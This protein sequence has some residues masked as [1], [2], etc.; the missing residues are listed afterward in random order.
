VLVAI[1]AER[2]RDSTAR[3][4]RD[5]VPALTL[6][7]DRGS[8]HSGDDA[9]RRD[10]PEQTLHHAIASFEVCQTSGQDVPQVR[11]GKLRS[12]PLRKRLAAAQP[13]QLLQT[14]WTAAVVP[15]TWPIIRP[16]RRT[17]CPAPRPSDG[18][19]SQGPAEEQTPAPTTRW[20]PR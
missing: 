13:S 16:V 4:H 20:P 12:G 8:P 15:P 3:A 9:E 11:N 7:L 14:R 19:G 2:D 17:D 10:T 18:P 6:R 5:P 1:V